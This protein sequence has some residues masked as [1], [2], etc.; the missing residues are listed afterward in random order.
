MSLCFL[1]SLPL[2]EC[3]GSARETRWHSMSSTASAAGR[4]EFGR[5]AA[6]A[7]LVAAIHGQGCH[8]LREADLLCRGLTLGGG[9][10]AV[11]V[12][13]PARDGEHTFPMHSLCGLHPSILPP[14]RA[15]YALPGRQ[16]AR[17]HALVSERPAAP[18]SGFSLTTC[19]PATERY[20]AQ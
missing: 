2:T 19:P 7:W 18:T 4:L 12:H 1:V 11:P 9:Q 13:L 20:D 8:G 17:S 3:R 15:G 14:I 16:A 10:A 5:V 6:T